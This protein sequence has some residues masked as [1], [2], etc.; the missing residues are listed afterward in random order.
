MALIVTF[1]DQVNG[2]KP[3]SHGVSPTSTMRW[4]SFVFDGC[5]ELSR[6]SKMRLIVLCRPP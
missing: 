1:I 4:F 2:K 3:D 6:S 5:E